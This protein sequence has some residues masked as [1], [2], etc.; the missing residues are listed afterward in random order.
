MQK[1]EK[2]LI[3]FFS[4]DQIHEIKQI[5]SVSDENWLIS[6]PVVTSQNNEV[7]SRAKISRAQIDLLITYAQ[8]KL[9]H[10]KQVQFFLTLGNT[11]KKTGEYDAAISIFDSLLLAT[12][13]E[14]K[15]S[16]IKINCFLAIADI[17]EKQAYW[18]ESLTLVKKARNAYKLQKDNNGI[19]F[20]ENFLGTIF[21]ERGN[22]KKAKSH[23]ELSL[24]L[25]NHAKNKALFGIIEI[26]LGILNNMQGNFDEAFTCF[27]R[28][29][30]IFEQ[31][32]DLNRIAELRHNIGMLF[33]QKGEFD[34]ALSEFD[35][36][37]ALFFEMGVL[38]KLGISYLSKAFIFTQLKDYHFASAFADKAMEIS[39]KLNDRLSMADI[40]KIKGIIERSLNNFK[41]SESYFLTSLRIN[42][43]LSNDLN[44]AETQ[45]EMG[46]LYVDME[47][48]D[49]ALEAFRSSLEY[50][51]NINSTDIVKKLKEEI[52]QLK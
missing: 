2:I 10:L 37:I 49:K 1:I 23:F 32:H 38:S 19:A 18:K 21:G 41:L 4:T 8:K 28:A 45:F 5:L 43:E 16:N 48:N 34:S 51:R 26:N 17:Y 31:T 7:D 27:H 36:S 25:L 22:I 14:S 47:L 44:K 12:G 13:N 24:S 52:F 39:D 29:L 35:K 20:C 50:F 30:V 15:L 42:L 6:S 11:V 40:Y 3:P 9:S 46:K 33:T